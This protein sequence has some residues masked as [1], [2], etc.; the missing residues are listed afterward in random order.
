MVRVERSWSLPFDPYLDSCAIRLRSKA[1]VVAGALLASVALAGAA[2]P[3][4][5]AD[6][7]GKRDPTT[8]LARAR[9][10]MGFTRVQGRVLHY[11]AAAVVEQNFQS[12]RTYPPFFS[13]VSQQEVWFQPASGVLRVQ[14]QTTFPGIPQRTSIQLD[15]GSN[16][17][18]LR[19]EQQV[20]ISRRQA[21]ARYLSP[22]AVIA[23]WS[24][25]DDIRVVGSEVYRDY[26]RV[27]LSRQ[28]SQGEQ[29]LFLD[30]K[31]GF[32]VKLDLVEPHYLWGQR[33]IE[34][35]WTTWFEQAG[36]MMPGSSSRI[37]DG[38]PEISLT[39]G[40][41]EVIGPQAA[42]ALHPLKGP[43]VPP[44]DLPIFLQP[45]PPKGIQITP[46]LLLLSNPGYY[47]LVTLANNELYLFDSTQGEE[48]AREDEAEIA[49]AFPG[50]HR[51]NLVVTDT[52]WPHI[53]GVRYWVSQG[54]TVI[55]HRANREFLQRVIDRHWTLKADSLE[56]LRRATPKAARMNFVPIEKTTPV[57]GG[58]LQLIPIEGIGSEVALMAYLPGEKFLW[59]SDYIQTVE[60]PSLYA[61]EVIRAA[62]RARIQP[63]RVAAEHVPVT[64]W[65]AVRAAQ[66]T[67]N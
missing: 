55:S 7:R 15:D 41:V 3:G 24:K 34:Y 57:A 14:A 52:S 63:E 22:W 65:N 61:A 30:P 62:E 36:L 53:A 17:A 10:V 60:E 51:I 25:A 2:A 11:H 67:R 33:H 39:A 9:E 19:G 47:E 49:K 29:R 45:I 46:N 37:A 28:T 42:P 48:R 64:D 16:I 43:S 27:V 50:R 31:S 59:A 8:L 4:Q 21:P 66:I 56:Q 26:P 12:D 38:D 58:V 35:V 1:A 23:D 20:P 18:T 40:P 54:V 13:S 32:P 44:A 5:S 6:V